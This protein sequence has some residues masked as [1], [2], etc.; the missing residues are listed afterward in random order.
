M[1]QMETI[2]KTGA[3]PL[4]TGDTGYGDVIL[5]VTSVKTVLARYRDGKSNEEK[6]GKFDI[7][8]S[9][10]VYAY[11]ETREGVSLRKCL[12]GFAEKLKIAVTD[13]GI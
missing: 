7:Y 3:T 8:G 5:S 2:T 13:K 11:I 4:A 9:G 6:I 12:K 1:P 10:D